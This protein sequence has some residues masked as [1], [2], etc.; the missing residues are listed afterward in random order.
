M[1][2]VIVWKLED[3]TVIRKET[4]TKLGFYQILSI[5]IIPA[6]NQHIVWINGSK[7]NTETNDTV[8]IYEYDRE[9]KICQLYNDD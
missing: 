5:L 8:I 3:N 7:T 1:K 9:M 6:F 2:Y 4:N